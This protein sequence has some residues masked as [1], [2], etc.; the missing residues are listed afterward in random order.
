VRSGE[1]GARLLFPLAE[2]MEGRRIGPKLARLR[3]E[4][5]EP[6]EARRRRQRERLTAMV[7]HAGAHVP[8]YRELF[9][10][11]GFDP[12]ALAH[13][14][15]AIAALPPLDRDTLVEAGPRLLDERL[16]PGSLHVRRTGGS[17]GRAALVRYSSEALDWTAAVN[18][19]VREWAGQA[20]FAPE[21]H[22]STAPGIE[23]PWRD[24][25]RER[26]KCASLNRTNLP[27]SGWDAETLDGLCR[28]LAR[29]RP[30][31]V[32][33]HPSTLQALAHHVRQAGGLAAPLFGVFESTGETLDP[34]A[35]KLIEETLRCAVV[36]RYGSAEFG[37]AAYERPG[38]RPGME[39]LDGVVFAETLP[40]GEGH[41]ELVLTGLLNAAMPLL[42]YRTG[43]LV[44]LACEPD[45]VAGRIVELH[46]RI[47]DAVDLGGRRVPTHVI[48]DRLDRFGCVEE[49]QVE[50]GGD[51]PPRL[52]VAAPEAEHERIRHGVR[53][54]WGDA[55]EIEFSARA[56]FVRTGWR[57]K[58]RHLVTRPES[59]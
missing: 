3:A 17:T 52:R 23:I 19:F 15:S 58:H 30:A 16:D 59:A 54:W 11:S 26:L 27:I 32:Q 44:R 53:A 1:L 57:G 10:R 47:H 35:R 21:A 55:L 13:D 8:H 43:D 49:F 12:E 22:L 42:R 48:Q 18:L 41:E 6:A 39:V 5:A 28:D 56:G 37:V 24:R 33:G 45:E 40:D 29:A 46:G 25:A 14:A 50:V 2:H 20:P 9:A 36:D 4:A 7:R 38:G 31:L 34:S 51:R